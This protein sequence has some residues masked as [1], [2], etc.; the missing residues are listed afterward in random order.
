MM[1]GACQAEDNDKGEEGSHGR[2]S[3]ES[4][5]AGTSLTMTDLH[6]EVNNY[7]GVAFFNETR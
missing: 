4:G 1:G 6:R 5:F 2:V 7:F 3:S